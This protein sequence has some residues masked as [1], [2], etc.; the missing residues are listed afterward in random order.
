MHAKSLKEAAP[1]FQES[2]L[3]KVNSSFEKCMQSPWK[4]QSFILKKLSF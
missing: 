4:K 1:Y 3:S 2:A